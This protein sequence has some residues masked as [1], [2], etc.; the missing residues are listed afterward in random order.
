[1]LAMWGHLTRQQDATGRAQASGGQGPSI[2]GAFK[3]V[4]EGMAQCT[5]GFRTHRGLHCCPDITPDA[6]CI[7]VLHKQGPLGLYRGLPAQLVGIMPEK[8]LKLTL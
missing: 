4:R 1:V 3:E 8:A 6:S 2:L 7:Q 5:W